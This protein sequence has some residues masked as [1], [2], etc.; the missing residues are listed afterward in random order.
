M[1]NRLFY[2]IK[3][4]SSLLQEFQYNINLSFEDA[5]SAGLVISLSDSQMLKSIRDITGQK[6]DRQQLEEW[7]AE[8]DRLK[9][10]KS[11]TKESE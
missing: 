11:N 3:L 1:R 2:T 10:S 9:K 6:I 8:R 7:F 5:L 4:S